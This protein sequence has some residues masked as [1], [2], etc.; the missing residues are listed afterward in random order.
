MKKIIFFT[1]LL[2]AVLGLNAQEFKVTYSLSRELL[3]FVMIID[4]R[5]SQSSENEFEKN[6]LKE[7]HKGLSFFIGFTTTAIS[8]ALFANQK[9]ITLSSYSDDVQAVDRSLTQAF[10]KG[11]WTGLQAG[12]LSF[13]FFRMFYAKKNPAI[14]DLGFVYVIELISKENEF[15]ALDESLKYVSSSRIILIDRWKE[16]ASAYIPLL[17]LLFSALHYQKI[18]LEQQ[19]STIDTTCS[20]NCGE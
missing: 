3:N 8:T 7:L 11:T 12:L 16:K 2:N 17:D 9:T 18:F 15:A 5:I 13:V 6:R 4:R 19:K 20:H 1:C 10:A 14:P